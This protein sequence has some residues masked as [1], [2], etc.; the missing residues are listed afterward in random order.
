[1][2]IYLAHPIAARKMIRERELATE[3]R[4]GVE[5]LN[6]FYDTGRGD[7][8]EID[9]GTRGIWEIDPAPVVEGDIKDIEK[10]H[11]FAAVLCDGL[12]IGTIMETVYA[13][14]AGKRVYIIDLANK[15]GHPWIRYHASLIFSSWAAFDKFLEH[16]NRPEV[17]KT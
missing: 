12:S 6:P 5:L 1:M 7:I 17:E 2:Q 16:M 13:F 3:Q 9:A 11:A 4:T 10:C 15:C 14:K 8:E